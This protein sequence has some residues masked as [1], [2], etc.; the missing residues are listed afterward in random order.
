MARFY[1]ESRRW[2]LL[3][4]AL[5]A[6][7]ACGTLLIG[8]GGMASAATHIASVSKDSLPPASKEARKLP[9]DVESSH[10][11]YKG[12]TVVFK[13]IVITQGET[14]VQADHAH[15]TDIDD[16]QNSRWTFEGNVRISGEQHGSLHSDQAVVEFRNNHI[17]KATINGN[18]AE[19]EQKRADT[20]QTARGHARQIV[21]DLTDGTVVLSNDAWLSDGHNEIS[22][23]QLV[24]NIREQ[25]IQASA[26]PGSDQRVRIVIPAHPDEEPNKKP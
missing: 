17:S 7:L 24:Y 18:P 6:L 5:A 12:D 9:I 19:F 16:F 11:D 10:V 20:D 21:Y 14:R 25:R 26:E 3:Q 22:G 15:A 13:D 2:R 23:P 4:H 1:P 8:A